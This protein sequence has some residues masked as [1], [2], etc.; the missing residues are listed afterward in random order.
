MSATCWPRVSQSALRWMMV[1]TA[2]DWRR[3]DGSIT[4][5]DGNTF[6]SSTDSGRN[7]WNPGI[8]AESWNSGGIPAALQEFR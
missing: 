7:P 5:A 4:G 1:V 2:L 6:H 8:P 3:G